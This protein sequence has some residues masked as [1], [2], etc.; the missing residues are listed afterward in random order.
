MSKPT[1][2]IEPPWVVYPN[3]HPMEFFWRDAGQPW[4]DY[5]WRPFWHSLSEE[6]QAKYLQK[7]PAPKAWLESSI[8]LNHEL[9]K[10]LRESDDD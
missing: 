1:N 2:I 6:E 8:D 5:F 3:I 4:L 7:Y 10:L 9:A